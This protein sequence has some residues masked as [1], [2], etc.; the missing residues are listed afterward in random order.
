MHQ[1]LFTL[2]CIYNYL[3]YNKMMIFLIN[4][5]KTASMNIA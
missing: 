4:F 5:S 3:Q 1:G 2:N